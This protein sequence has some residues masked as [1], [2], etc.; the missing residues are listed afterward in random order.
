MVLRK[1]TL[2]EWLMMGDPVPQQSQG[3]ERT[4]NL[5][6]NQPFAVGKCVPQRRSP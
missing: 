2:D 6:A 5:S 3:N 4:M 1:V